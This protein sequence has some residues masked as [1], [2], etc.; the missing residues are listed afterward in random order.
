MVRD[1]CVL[2]VRGLET[3]HRLLPHGRPLQKRLELAGGPQERVIGTRGRQR[4]H[5]RRPLRQ[6]PLVPLE[7]QPQRQPHEL[8]PARREPGDDRGVRDVHGRD[9]EVLRDLDEGLA[10]AHVVDELR[11]AAVAEADRLGRATGKALLDGEPRDELPGGAG[12]DVR[13]GGGG[14][15]DGRGGRARDVA[16][17]SGGGG[18]RARRGPRG[19][20][21][22]RRHGCL[23]TVAI[24]AILLRRRGDKIA[25]AW[26]RR[27]NYT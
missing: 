2:V 6:R 9:G 10:R 27:A 13:G 8:A 7:A 24:L 25:T 20:G 14:G 11:D 4:R 15:R 26:D 12:V 18:G 3:R 22:R 17:A 5:V 1:G 16:A 21:C 23:S 19:E